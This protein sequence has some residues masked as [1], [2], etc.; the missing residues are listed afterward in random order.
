MRN[1][2]ASEDIVLTIA[3]FSAF[4]VVFS[5]KLRKLRFQISSYV[6]LL[7]FSC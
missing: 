5:Y 6:A 7:N 3:P 1:L 4:I 2:S